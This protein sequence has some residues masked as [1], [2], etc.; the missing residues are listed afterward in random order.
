[1]SIIQSELLAP[2]GSYDSLRAA[3]NAGADAMYIGGSNF[4][5]R[6]FAEN[7]DETMMLKAIDLVHLHNKK[8]Y[9]TVN[10]LL[11]NNELEEQLY[12]Y[13]KPL[14]EEG[15]DAVIVQDLGVF[16]FFRDN[17][18]NLDVHASTQMTV[19]GIDSARLM[20][21]QGATRIVTARELS[22]KE[23]KHIHDN[24]DIEIESFIHGALCYCYSGQ[25]LL[26]SILGG[27]SGNRGRCAQPCRLPY[28][29]NYNNISNGKNEK[30]ILSPKDMCTLKIIPE[31]LEVGVY[32]LKIE[33]RMKSPEYVAGVVEIYR[34][35]ID[36]YKEYGKEKYKVTEK[37]YGKLTDL[38]SRSGFTE[39]YYKKHN[40]RDMITLGKP[41]YS[42]VNEG[43]I[44]ELTEKYVTKDK[45][46]K[47][48]MYSSIK[49]DEPMSLT[50][51]YNDTSITVEGGIPEL[52]NNK[53]ATYDSVVKQLSKLGNTDFEIEDINVVLDDNLFVPVKMLNELRRSAITK[54]T[55]NLLCK[56]KRLISQNDLIFNT[57]KKT[58]YYK[59]HLTF[60]CSVDN[61]DQMLAAADS[62]YVDIIYLSSDFMTDD[63]ISKA[64]DYIHEKNKK[65]FINLPFIL[66]NQKGLY[67]GKQDGVMVRNVDELQFMNEHNQST[68]DNYD[69]HSDY[70]LYTMNDNAKAFVNSIGVLSTTTPLELNSHELNGRNNYDDIMIVYGHLP[71]MVTA[72]CGK[73][74]MNSCDGKDSIYTLKDRYQKIFK[75]KNS[76]K[77]CYNVMYNC[78][79]LS[80]LKFSNEIIK[81]NFS[82]IKLNFTFENKR[83]VQNIINLFGKKFIDNE[84]PNSDIPGYTK[85][86]YKRKVE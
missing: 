24:V 79:P 66:R 85:G 14:Y 78:S 58:N 3:I 52:S 76:C 72:G 30:Y 19:T 1:M 9:L 12:N 68:D 57:P 56:H 63:E 5:A 8:L 27:R 59:K 26:S 80:L 44:N 74:T 81:M 25:C 67:M 50:V 48:S 42:S 13:V 73:K 16:K 17:F 37:D 22:L 49:R 47:I 4:G 69:V 38:Y 62:N 32:S 86:H 41:S 10:T 70:S 28:D 82:N 40:G 84:E 54:L 18:P 35:Y 43:R 7:L 23:L 60:S 75:V 31:I 29:Y 64:I 39:G 15:L 53:P 2:A 34:K 61:Y 6:A 36:L 20:K 11:K 83:E 21:E 51:I 33:G 71:L 77:N 55:I 45:K 65:A 46:L